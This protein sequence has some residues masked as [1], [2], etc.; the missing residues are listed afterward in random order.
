MKK[1][2]H[3]KYYLLFVF[4]LLFTIPMKAQIEVDTLKQIWTNPNEVDSIRFKAINQFYI[5]NTHAQPDLSLEV[6]EYHYDLAKT[7]NSIK[8][9]ANAKNE[10]GYVYYIK[11]TPDFAMQALTETENL[12]LQIG[13]TLKAGNIYNNKGAIYLEQSKYPEAIRQYSK[14]LDLFQ[15]KNLKKEETAILNNLGL[16]YYSIDDLD[17]ALEYFN[18]ALKGYESLNL[19]H[20]SGITWI[21]IASNNI[22][23][24][25]YEKALSNAR[26]GVNILK[27]YNNNFAVS[28]GYF[29]MAKAFQNLNQLDSAFHYIEK[30]LAFHEAIQNEAKTFERL[31]LKANLTFYNSIDLATQDAE[32]ILKEVNQISSNQSKVDLYQLLYKCYKGKSRSDLSLKML[33]KSNLYSDSV[34]LEKN[35]NTVIREALQKDFD[36]RIQANQLENDKERTKLKSAELKKIFAISLFAGLSILSLLWV[37]RKKNKENKIEKEALLKEIEILKNKKHSDLVVSTTKFKLNREKIESSINRKINETDWK[38]LNILLEDPVI[39]NKEIAK[40]A[41]MS[42]D[43]IGSSLIRMYTYFDVKKSKYKKISL[44]MDAI[45]HSNKDA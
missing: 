20:E 19:I 38:I 5:A 40:K 25:K 30:S 18:K 39:T 16:V 43:G 13:D 12:L 14:A 28:D 29:V 36:I 7:K 9:M 17:L 34:S 26:K 42:V 22:K 21:H 6:I 10:E 24:K 2:L 4:S 32:D 11:G 37:F 45:K 31:I 41:I 27:K 44:L 8:E 35:K 1:I 33:E 3:I 23:F 15:T